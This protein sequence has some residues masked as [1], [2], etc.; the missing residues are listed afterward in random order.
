[1]ALPNLQPSG[2]VSAPCALSSGS[3]AKPGLCIA[4]RVMKIGAPESIARK[5][6]SE[7]ILEVRIPA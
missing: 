2:C 5:P 7:V 3:P 4:V 1:M 6:Q